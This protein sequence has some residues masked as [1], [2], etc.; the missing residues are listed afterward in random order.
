MIQRNSMIIKSRAIGTFALPLLLSA[1]GQSGDRSSAGGSTIASAPAAPPTAPVASVV[2]DDCNRRVGVATAAGI[3]GVT[4]ATENV[5][6]GHTK[7]SPDQMDVLECGYHEASPDPYA[8]FMKFVVFTP[9]AADIA[10]VYSSM[11]PRAGVQ[12]IDTHLGMESTGWIRPGAGPGLFEAHI[13]F[14]TASNIFQ[15]EVAGLH[16]ADAATDAALKLAG[17][18]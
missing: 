3:L 9:I 2:A 5:Y 1:C 7:Q 12:T 10:S 17:N 13:T 6:F 14:R 8:P 4:K 15:V 11:S 18:L 16:G